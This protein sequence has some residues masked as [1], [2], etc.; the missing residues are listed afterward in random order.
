MR[1][2]RQ[3]RPKAGEVAMRCRGETGQGLCASVTGP[4]G[5]PCPQCGRPV[6]P[7]EGATIMEQPRQKADTL[8]L[9]EVKQ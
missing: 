5:T 8:I 1:R 4:P 3:R 9:W 7:R 6:Y 2:N